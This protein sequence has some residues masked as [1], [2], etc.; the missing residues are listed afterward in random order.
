LF[1]RHARLTHE[2][3]NE[4]IAAARQSFHELWRCRVVAKRV[5]QSADGRVHSVLEINERVVA[6]QA[7]SQFVARNQVTRSLEKRFEDLE[8]LTLEGHARPVLAELAGAKIQFKH[9]EPND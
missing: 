5:T 4:A 6:P 3:C 1:Q 2:R 8:R 7:L 9:T